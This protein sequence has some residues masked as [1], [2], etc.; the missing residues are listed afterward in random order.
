MSYKARDKIKNHDGP[1]KDENPLKTVLV[2]QGGAFRG[3]H[4]NGMLEVLAENNICFDT[5]MGI[6][7]GALNGMTYTAGLDSIRRAVRI[8]TEFVSD[9]G[10]TNL[11]TIQEEHSLINFDLLF[12]GNGGDLEPFD[13]AGY[14]S[15]PTHFECGA[16]NCDSGQIEYFIK[17]EVEDMRSAVIASCSIPLLCPMVE[18]KGTSYLDGGIAEALMYHKALADGYGKIVLMLTREKGFRPVEN[19]AAR[20]AFLRLRY[21]SRP[22]LQHTLD[23][24]T[25]RYAALYEE[26]EQ[27]EAERKR[28]LFVMRPF[29][30]INVD[31]L[32]LNT[33][34]MTALYQQGRSEAELILP[35]LQKFL[36]T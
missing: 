25:T 26:I 16:V 23:E 4:T 9:I 36:Q 5:I 12:D 1:S 8:N 7:A 3:V 21:L 20:K 28:G 11:K 18:I 15:S 31:L 35:A 19:S 6:S 29:K 14:E 10:Y 27:A 2:I 30:P 24:Q 17:G 33:E 34:Q 13:F 22:N 32:N